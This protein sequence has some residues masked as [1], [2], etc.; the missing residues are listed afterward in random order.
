MNYSSLSDLKKSIFAF[1]MLLA[2]AL[3]GCSK[4]EQ[5]RAQTRSPAAKVVEA[6]P[7]RQETVQ[8]SVEVIGTLAALDEV[9]V[10]S[11]VEGA[12]GKILA[13]LGDPVTAGQVMVEL[14][15]EK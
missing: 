11:E 6:E 13:D 1:V 8:R 4:S 14:D 5:A 9:T 2:V 12:V 3:T 15:R 10:S 7:V